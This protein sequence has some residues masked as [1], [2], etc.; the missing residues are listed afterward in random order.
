[1]TCHEN[2]ISLESGGVGRCCCG[3]AKDN[4]IFHWNTIRFQISIQH[5]KSRIN[6]LYLKVHIFGALKDLSKNNPLI[7]WST[8][9]L[10][11]LFKASGPLTWLFLRYYNAVVFVCLNGYFQSQT[12]NR[13]EFLLYH[14]E[15]SKE[16][17]RV[18]F[19]G[20]SCSF[21]FPFHTPCL[22]TV[23]LVKV[24]HDL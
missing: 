17:K 21:E 1:M 22:A 24:L 3:G 14:I 13:I 10:Y 12:Y 7:I 16:Q 23:L 11:A 20:L 5:P 18:F 2:E 9:L 8:Y 19:Q 15:N 4:T 6:Q